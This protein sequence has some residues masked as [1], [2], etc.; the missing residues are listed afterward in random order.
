MIPQHLLEIHKVETPNC[1]NCDRRMLL[2]RGRFG[3]FWAC[4]DFP[5][6]RST[7]PF[8]A[9]R[10]DPDATSTLESE[11]DD[12]L[13]EMTFYYHWSDFY[14]DAPKE[15]DEDEFDGSFTADVTMISPSLFETEEPVYLTPF[16]FFGPRA[17]IRVLSS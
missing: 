13:K 6:N 7:L 3:I 12:E 2:R 1:P 8:V 16:G 15:D 9:I 17:D 4:A 5:N 14:D 11:R 10:R